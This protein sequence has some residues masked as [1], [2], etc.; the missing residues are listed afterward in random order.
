MSEWLKGN[1]SWLVIIA[2]VAI[3]LDV[4]TRYVTVAHFYHYN[5]MQSISIDANRKNISVN[6]SAIAR[7]YG[8]DDSKLCIKREV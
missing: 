2:V 3:F 4:Q 7:L 1:Q 5:D 8:R 6:A